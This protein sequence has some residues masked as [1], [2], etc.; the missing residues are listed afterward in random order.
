MP[1][2]DADF[3]ADAA[4]MDIIDSASDNFKILGKSDGA[5]VYSQSANSVNVKLAPGKYRV[6]AYNPKSGESKIVSKSVK[7]NGDYTLDTPDNTSVY[8][9]RKL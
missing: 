1:V 3:L 2:K 8:W 9:F 6:T 7:I 5:I 4:A